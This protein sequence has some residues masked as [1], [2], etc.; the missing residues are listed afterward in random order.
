M[1]V[2]VAWAPQHLPPVLH[3]QGGI[4]VFLAALAVSLLT[5][6]FFGVATGAGLLV[7]VGVGMEVSA[8]I[9]DFLFGVSPS[10]PAIYATVAGLLTVVALVACW[11]PARRATRVDPI[12][13]LRGE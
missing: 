4:R 9:K 6:L 12:A 5:G 13:I 10:H 8:T 1:S 7:G 2:F 3:I 11:I